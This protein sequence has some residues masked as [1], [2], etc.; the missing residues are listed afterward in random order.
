MRPCAQPWAGFLSPALTHGSPSTQQRQHSLRRLLTILHFAGFT[1]L[2]MRPRPRAQPW[3][4]F[5]PPVPTQ[6]GPSTQPSG[7]LS[8]TGAG[9]SFTGILSDQPEILLQTL[10]DAAALS[11]S[12]AG[13]PGTP[14]ASTGGS[15]VVAAETAWAAVAAGAGGVGSLSSGSNVLGTPRGPHLVA[16]GSPYDLGSAGLEQP[17][18]ARMPGAAYQAHPGW[19]TPSYGHDQA[20]AA[21]AVA[22]WAMPMVRAASAGDLRMLPQG[23][24]GVPPAA[25]QPPPAYGTGLPPLA[26]PQP[27]SAGTAAYGGWRL[28]TVDLPVAPS[29][30]GMGRPRANSLLMLPGGGMATRG[31]RMRSNSYTY[32]GYADFASSMYQHAG[33]AAWGDLSPYGSY[34]VSPASTDSASTGGGTAWQQLPPPP[35]T[36]PRQNPMSWQQ[37]QQQLQAHHAQQALLQ[38]QQLQSLQ[39]AYRGPVVTG[40][41]QGANGRRRRHSVCM[42]DPRLQ[43]GMGHHRSRRLSGMRNYGPLM[44]EMQPWSEVRTAELH[45]CGLADKAGRACLSCAL[46][47]HSSVMCQLPGT[48]CCRQHFRPSGCIGSCVLHLCVEVKAQFC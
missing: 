11:G 44:M 23:S 25:V 13:V 34:V 30:M 24:L 8:G 21:A 5:P 27:P 43:L 15:N 40:D 48:C 42:G 1:A 32:G 28:P 19:V 10:T 9:P 7:P 14:G 45:A 22:A 29:V 16:R 20:A 33:A 36:T 35:V 47:V 17:G 31:R 37:Q 41:A 26:P 18:L 3:A 6:G 46:A 39:A 4:G 2:Q 38:Q 12:H